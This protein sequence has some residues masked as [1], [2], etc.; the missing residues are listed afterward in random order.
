MER[1]LRKINKAALKFLQPLSLEETYINIVE[2]AIKLV[3]TEFGSIFLEQDGNLHRVYSSS[4]SFLTI[5]PRKRGFIHKTFSTRKP[6]VINI[7]KVVKIHPKLA[8][9]GVK[10]IVIIPLAYKNKSIGVLTTQ[11]SKSEHFSG[12]DLEV[13]KL[14]GSM[15]SLAIRKNQ[16]YQESIRALETRDLFISMAAHELRTPLTSVNGYIQLLYQKLAKPGSEDNISRWVEQLSWESSR[17]TNLVNELLEINR[18]KNEQL[19]YSWKECNLQEI[20]QRSLVNFKFTN[21]QREVVFET[22]TELPV[23][24]IGDFDKLIQAILNILDNAAKFSPNDSII[25]LTLRVKKRFLILEIKDYGKGIAKK[26]LKKIFERFYRISNSL[27]EGMGIGLFLAKYI[28]V[29][30]KGSIK[31]FSKLNKGTRVEVRL[32]IATI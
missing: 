16:L 15:A 14:F 8:Q 26:E 17:L 31:V 9:I 23:G 27:V 12:R 3:G 10:F 11:T 22:D 25:E 1:T 2:E 20:I 4:S 30:H 6:M 24:V 29:S 21:P 28:I 7:S 13:L 19:Q 18:I 5:Q 32:P